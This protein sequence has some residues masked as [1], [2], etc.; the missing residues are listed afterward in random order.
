MPFWVKFLDHYGIDILS[1]LKKL[2]G[3]AL[4]QRAPIQIDYDVYMLCAIFFTQLRI[5]TCSSCNY[6]NFRPVELER[7]FSLKSTPIGI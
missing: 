2:V 6:L 5:F 7:K 4:L 1:V 3:R